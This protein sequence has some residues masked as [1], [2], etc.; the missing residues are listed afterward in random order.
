MFFNKQFTNLLLIP[1]HL[2]H[3]DQVGYLNY[4]NWKA[5][6]LISSIKTKA[7]YTQCIYNQ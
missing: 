6:L 7:I 5:T 1:Y 2:K 3:N 4:K